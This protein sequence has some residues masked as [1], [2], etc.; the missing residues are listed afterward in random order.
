MEY[1]ISYRQ[2]LRLTS[3]FFLILA[4]AAFIGGC[5]QPAETAATPGGEPDPAPVRAQS[6]ADAVAAARPGDTIV[7]PAGLYKAGA[8]LKLPPQVSL[9][10]AGYR[11][12][13]LDA[14]QADVGV[15]IEGGEGAELA[16]LTVWGAG[17]TSVLVAGARRVALRRVRT[18]GGLGGVN[19]VDVTD[20]RIENVI[21][22]EN[23]YGIVVS[24]GRGNTVVNCTLV[25]NSSLGLSF[26]SGEGTRAFNNCIVDCATGVYLGRRIGEMQLDHNLYFTPFVGKVAGQ[27]GRKTLGD[28]QSLSGQDA[29]SV[30]LPVT[31]RDAARG[32]YRPAGTLPWS[33]ERAPTAEWGTAV[34]AGADA[35]A[36][37][38]DGAARAG[39]YDVG[40]FEVPPAAN[41]PR[42][43]DGILTIR[44]DQGLK[45]AGVFAPGGRLV[46]Y[47]F[48]DL[49]LPAGPHAYWL[50]PRDFEGRTIAAGTYD[51][52]TV[53][54]ALRWEY[55]HWV[56]D[57]GAVF[58]PSQTAAVQPSWCAFDGGGRLIVGQGWSEDAT[59]LRA[60][61]AAS[62]QWL[63]AFSGSSDL[64]GLEVGDD[65]AIYILK[66]SG[67]K[68]LIARIDPRT[69]RVA[70]W[71]SHDTGQF[72]FEGGGDAL[73]LAILSGRLYVA[74]TKA[75][76]IRYGPLDPPGLDQ[77][78]ALAAPTSLAAD[79]ATGRLWAISG[80]N[81]LVALDPD[82]KRLADVAPLAAPAALAARDGRLAVASRA[83]G[84]VH[85][86]DAHDPQ[87]L[88]R[89]GTLGTGD[90][91]F[92]PYQPDRFLF[93]C[94]PDAPGCDVKL[95]LGAD[96][97]LAVTDENRLLVFDRQGKSLWTTFGLFGDAC[98]PSFT[99][100]GRVFTRDGRKSIR[101][102]EASATWSPDAFWD[103]PRGQFLGAFAADAM[104]FGV[105]VLA[106]IPQ[107]HGPLLVV[108]YDGHAARRVLQLFQDPAT[109][110]YLARNDTNHDGRLD[111]RDG[112]TVMAPPPE[113]PHPL[114]GGPLAHR[115]YSTLQPDGDIVT[116]NLHA[117]TW[118]VI[119]RFG[120]LDREGVPQ[121]RLEDCRALVRKPGGFLSPY[122]S[123]PQDA[124][125]L[126]AAVPNADGGFTGL[127]NDPSSPWGTGLLNNAGTDLMRL[128]DAG[129][130]LWDHPLPEH[131]GLEGLERAGPLL[132]TGVGV[133]CEILA[134]NHD[135]LGMGSFGFP[136]QVH[137]LGFFLDHPGAV[138]AYRGGD[139]RIY[140][141]IADKANGMQHWY[142]LHGEETIASTSSAI[143]LQEP[144]ARQLAALPAPAGPA[145][146][147]PRAP[148]IRVPHLT[149]DL[150]IDGDL[151]KW[152]KAGVAP[153]LVVTPETA[154][155]AIDGPLDVSAVIRLAYRGNALYLQALSFDDV[156]S[157]HQPVV[158]HDQQ[159]GI[160]LCIN[161]FLPGFK[162]DITSTNDAGPIVIRQRFYY[163][164]LDFLIP[165]GHAP[166]SIKVLKDARD[167]PERRLI[168]SI[169]GVDM[170]ESPVIVTECKLPIDATTYK[171]SV[172]DLFPLKPGQTFRLG[173]L[174]NDNDD[175]GTDVQNYLVWPATY[176]NFNP[177]DD[178]AIAVLE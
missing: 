73:G 77:T 122:T 98:Q 3:V 129:A 34:L 55:L 155:G 5:G 160:E 125:V 159:D 2:L 16:D 111:E 97:A 53:E 105:F 172:Q 119:W 24:G 61:D 112:G 30:R 78:I 51:L 89:E 145:L 82:G 154:A 106:D 100:P 21:S 161:G 147:K 62:G 81:R 41:L 59:N 23:R 92:G 32:D 162:F 76:V 90:G 18:T 148:T 107:Q 128:D 88:R 84:R 102:V 42:S 166:R 64:Q 141:L 101:L 176:G 25:Q 15:A 137:Y 165:P 37:D 174:I 68:G 85:F 36:S 114:R 7:L 8:G 116:L 156:P 40:A 74:D 67:S 142:R 83:S 144:A 109:G 139:G 135:G 127:F 117:D 150:P 26:P 31:F 65:G 157:F 124:A 163:Q 10:G 56:G 143:T 20:G 19:F 75:G 91:P 168:E 140:A 29:H 80:G 4:L 126:V 44:S 94:A 52:R 71:G 13:I 6:L 134:F 63:W 93:Q 131:K 70:P 118:G 87:A 58:P 104:T 9:R 47:L 14:R 27:L 146:A 167:V 39:R 17:K 121:Y 43:P 35:P 178:M 153:Q 22:D 86:Y 99:D 11:Q 152:R 130:M 171:D 79:R 132:L 66:R 177:V 133:T 113:G 38:I 151:A 115:V 108:R 46:G 50:P 164:N 173:V 138:R 136:P 28:W 33:L 45:S 170:A 1:Q 96:G 103:V 12:T 120:G 123:R 149:T 169:Y 72:A 158:R 48:H 49:P 54:S 95:A 69:G 57:S 60:Y 110:R 175:P